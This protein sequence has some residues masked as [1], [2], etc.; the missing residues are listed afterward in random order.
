MLV[1]VEFHLQIVAATMEV[2]YVAKE[3]YVEYEEKSRN[4]VCNYEKCDV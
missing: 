4:E 2:D 1:F 3:E